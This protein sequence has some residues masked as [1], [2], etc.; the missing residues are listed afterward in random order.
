MQNQPINSRPQD[1]ENERHSPEN[2]IITSYDEASASPVHQEQSEVIPEP[3]EV[4][5]VDL[6]S[7]PQNVTPLPPQNV[8]PL[9][10]QNSAQPQEPV[11]EQVRLQEKETEFKSESFSTLE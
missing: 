10:P 5:P 7:A 8:T 2:C 9:P 3:S 6:P 4:P 1:T 11:A